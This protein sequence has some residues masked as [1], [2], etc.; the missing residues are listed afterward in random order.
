MLHKKFARLFFPV[1]YLLLLLSLLPPFPA[2]A[3]SKHLVADSSTQSVP[4]AVT[5]TPN[6]LYTGAVG[7]DWETFSHTFTEA[8]ESRYYCE[9]HGGP[10][11]S[12]MAGRVVVQAS[13]SGEHKLYLPLVAQ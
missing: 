7:S 10:G 6:N 4:A 8:G 3:A 13:G 5:T 1:V 9:L 11:G 2:A 12:G